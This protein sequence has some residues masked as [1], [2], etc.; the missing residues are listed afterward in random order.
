MLTISSCSLNGD[1]HTDAITQDC[2]DCPLMRRIPSG[3]FVPFASTDGQQVHIGQPFLLGQ[4]EI[5]LQ[6]F[7]QFVNETNR[8]EPGRCFIFQGVNDQGEAQFG[9]VA[10]RNFNNP[11]YPQSGN[12]PAA[13]ISWDDAVAY[14]EW[15]SRKTGK[16]YR[17][18]SEAEFE[19][20]TRAGSNTTYFW[21][22]DAAAV[23]Q[24]ANAADQALQRAHPAF[25]DVA[26]CD[27]GYAYT[28]PVG[29]YRPNAFGLHDMIGNV[30]E[31]TA[32]CQHAAENLPVNGAAYIQDE[33]AQHVRRSASWFR[34]GAVQR[35]ALPN[36]D[37]HGNAGFRVARDL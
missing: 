21:G 31:W 18:P 37:W 4:H 7:A 9:W 26:Q 2:I 32:D 34:L 12:S 16:R 17:L 30:W 6:Q 20:A 27:D 1:W 22:N 29:S 3:S 15:L 10:G 33:C 5:T 35:S 36:A 14:A 8:P 25:Q 28:A 23:C 24:Y 19:Y 13:C 11:G